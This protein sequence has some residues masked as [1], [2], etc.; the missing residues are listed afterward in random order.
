MRKILFLVIVHMPHK[1]IV[2]PFVEKDHAVSYFN[3]LLEEA[4]A[5][6]GLRD[7][8]G[9]SLELCKKFFYYQVKPGY[10]LQMYEAALGEEEKISWI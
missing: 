9:G 2:C 7:Y 4:A 3:K 5:K 8:N 10:F 6:Y 1:S